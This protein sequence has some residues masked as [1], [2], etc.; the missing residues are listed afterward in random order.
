M[1]VRA[2]SWDIW[3]ILSSMTLAFFMGRFGEGSLTVSYRPSVVLIGP[4]KWNMAHIGGKG[5]DIFSLEAKDQN[6]KIQ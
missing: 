6:L 1:L 3:K 2:E 5:E 4:L